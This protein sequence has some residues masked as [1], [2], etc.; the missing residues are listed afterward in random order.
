MS[1]GDN[2]RANS[3]ERAGSEPVSRSAKCATAATVVRSAAG[4][5]PD[6]TRVL[7][8]GHCSTVNQEVYT[9]AVCEEPA[10]GFHFGAFTCEGCKSF[11]GRT[12]LRK[13]HERFECKNAGRCDVI[14]ANRTSCKACRYKRCV[15]VGMSPL[16]S[17]F[18]RRSKYF[19]VSMSGA[20]KQSTCA[21]PVLQPGAAVPFPAPVIYPFFI[22]NLLRIYALYHNDLCSSHSL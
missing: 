12:C 11:F 3:S 10:R 4:S 13:N 21:L 19:K 8:D 6:L 9:C 5:E 22:S 16:N 17:R 15:S 7:E 18:G 1:Q 20:Q 14:G 2:A